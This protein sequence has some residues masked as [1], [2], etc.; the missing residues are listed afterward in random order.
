MVFMEILTG[1]D[2]IL[3]SLASDSEVINKTEMSDIWIVRDTGFNLLNL[4]DAIGV[5]GGYFIHIMR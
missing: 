1:M 5:V 3:E 4:K 2:H